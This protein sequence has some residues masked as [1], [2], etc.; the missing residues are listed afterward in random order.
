MST[1]RFCPLFHTLYV[2]LGQILDTKGTRWRRS[3]VASMCLGHLR[4]CGSGE[5][6]GKG[7]GTGGRKAPPHPPTNVDYSHS[8]SCHLRLGT[9]MTQPP[10]SP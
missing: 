4:A 9:S 1:R 5:W 3:E 8:D 2:S 10:P 7:K 6:L